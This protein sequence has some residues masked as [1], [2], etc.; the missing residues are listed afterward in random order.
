MA[1]QD[2]HPLD[3]FKVMFHNQV[4]WKCLCTNIIKIIIMTVY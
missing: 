1:I 3:Q 2:P 4:M